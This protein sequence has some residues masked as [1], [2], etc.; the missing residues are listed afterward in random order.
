MAVKPGDVGI[1]LGAMKDVV[2]AFGPET[3]WYCACERVTLCGEVLRFQ[4]GSQFLTEHLAYLAQL[5][6][7]SRG[8]CKDMLPTLK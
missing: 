7:D 4:D 6:L 8:A 3:R 5:A 1:S 2:I